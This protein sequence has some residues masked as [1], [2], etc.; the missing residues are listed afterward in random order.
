[1][2][3][4]GGLWHEHYD[5]GS[6]VRNAVSADTAHVEI[7]GMPLPHRT[8]CISVA[9]WIEGVFTFK[10]GTVVEVRELGCRASGDPKCELTVTWR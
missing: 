3:I 7:V 9:G 1:V 4:A 5:A 6:L 10:P 2:E 8:H